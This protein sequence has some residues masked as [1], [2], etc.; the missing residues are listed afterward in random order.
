MT[1]DEDKKL[2]YIKVEGP[3][4]FFYCEVSRE[5]VAELCMVLKQVEAERH[6]PIYVHIHSEGG[7]LHAGLGCMD[8][9]KRMN[10]VT[11]AEGMC[12]S[13][14]TFIL[15]GGRIRQ[16]LENTYLLIHQMSNEIWGKYEELKDEMRQCERIMRRMK[17]IYMKE[18]AIPEKK[19]D[20]LMKRDLYLSY[21]KCVRYGICK[22]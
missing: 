3:H 4:I 19:L 2:E 17:K 5:T 13:A 18:T 20:R 7:D 8:F 11:I 9:I 12:A 15:L 22:E 6:S 21:R 16:V 14:A 1:T 10:V